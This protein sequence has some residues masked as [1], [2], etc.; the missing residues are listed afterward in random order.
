MS[1]TDFPASFRSCRA[2]VGELLAA[3]VDM[4]EVERTI[5]AYALDRDQKDALWLWAIGQR[6]RPSARGAYHPIIGRGAT[7]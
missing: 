3:G 5:E 2:G 1:S 4:A 6:E 7:R